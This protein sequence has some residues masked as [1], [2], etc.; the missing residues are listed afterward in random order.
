MT[1]DEIRRTFTEFFVA[2]DHLRLPS[3]SLI[4]AEHDP[5]ALFTIAGMHPLKSYFQGI[6]RPP[7]PRVNS[8]GSAAPGSVTT[9][10]APVM[11]AR[12]EEL[13]ERPADLGDHGH[14]TPQCRRGHRSSATRPG[15]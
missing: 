5:S 14:G 3:S 11:V 1:T 10:A 13:R 6:E 9:R 15:A 8:A 2:R 7:H 4:P 12:D